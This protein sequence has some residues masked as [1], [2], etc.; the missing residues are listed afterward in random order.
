[1]GVFYDVGRA[2]VG[3]WMGG[4]WVSRDE[5]R[6]IDILWGGEFGQE[7]SVL[8]GIDADTGEIVER[9]WIC[10]REFQCNV[11]PRNGTLWV[12]TLHGI[13]EYGHVLQSWTP[14]HGLRSH[15]FPVMSEQRFYNA[16]LGPD[17]RLWLG[18]HP[19]GRLVSYDPEADAWHDHGVQT[20]PPHVPGQ[21]VWCSPKHVSAA[22]EV[23]CG[24][25]RDPSGRVAYDPATDSTRVLADGEN[26]E[27]APSPAAVSR[28]ISASSFSKDGV[29][30]T[31]D[32]EERHAD[33][34]PTVATDI[35]GLH[36]GPDG[37]IYGATIISMHIFRFDPVSRDLEDL[38]K[39]GWG[40]GEVYDVIA[41][42]GKV[43][44]GSY[45]GGYFAAY[46]PD[47]PWNPRP[48]DGGEHP[49]AN[50][51]NF[52]RLGPEMNRPFEYTVGP[53]GRIYIACRAN[54]HVP[55]GG[56][57]RFDP[58][59]EQRK[60]FRD[61]DQS[62]QS[63]A[64]DET[65]VYGGTS[66]R[67]G[68][69]CVETTTEARLFM[70]CPREE[71]RVFEC[72]PEWGAIAVGNLACSPATGLVYGSTDTG[73]LFAFSPEQRRVMV[74]WSLDEEGTPLAGVPEA[75][76][77]VHL[78]AGR[79]GDIYGVSKT[80]IFKIDVSAERLVHLDKAPIPDLYQIV[81]GFE[82][83]VFYIGAR[84]HLL[85]YHLRDTPHFR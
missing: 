19:Q 58:E 54:Y 41:C 62:V 12:H 50:P 22:G 75:H 24:I 7:G 18:T 36:R 70:F 45:G 3:G 66:I 26:P 77:I 32:G 74:R 78:T 21:Q 27:P 47:R 14:E 71:R 16:V 85:E 11:D 56:L 53:D 43:Y 20:P 13:Y 35:C 2:V 81:E 17:G 76:G 73:G 84:G 40:G 79:D 48:G 4:G 65:W 42:G 57:A 55:G 64:S 33:Y 34:R 39:V 72:I 30:Y 31:V 9:H 23:V 67:G 82:D 68:R 1:M 10:G 6:G 59:T 83:G 61:E 46:D 28:S 37:R 29:T 15:G 44:M 8:F 60:V 25:Q 63:V 51:R 5:K 49:E 69:G 38:G 80:R 52:G